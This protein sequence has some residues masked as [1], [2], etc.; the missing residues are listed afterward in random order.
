MIIMNKKITAFATVLT[1]LIGQSVYFNKSNHSSVRYDQKRLIVKAKSKLAFKDIQ[2]IDSVRHFF[3]DIYI[4]RVSQLE[5]AERSLKENSNIISVERN[6]IQKVDLAN[7]QS[8]PYFETPIN[9]RVPRNDLLKSEHF[10]DPGVS[11]M[12]HFR[13]AKQAGITLDKA[14]TALK[15]K[16]SQAVIVAVVDTGVD[17][18]HEDLNGVMWIN[19][20][21]I[22]NN[23]IDDD[24]NGYVDDINGINTSERD[25]N[26]DATNKVMDK[27]S[28]GSHVSGI[29]AA[30]QNNNKGVAG[31]ASNVKIMAL[32]SVPADSDET[33]IDIAE[34]FLYAAKNGA[35]IINCSFGKR[36]NEG[37]NLIPDTLKYIADDYGVLVVI[38]AGNYTQNIDKNP[39]YPASHKNE[40]TL[41]VASTTS[42]A[43]LSS[44]SNYG[45]IG[46]DIAAPGDSI[47]STVLNNKYAMYSGTSMATPVV[48]GIAAEIWSHYPHLKYNEIKNILMKSA[49]YSDIL[50]KKVVSEGRV[51]LYN[52]YLKAE[53]L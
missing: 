5:K 21:E 28:H 45:F 29:I 40:N 12:W 27:H 26:G 33:D 19:K 2:N 24:K 48:A 4:V 10:N 49:T 14:Y 30:K 9:Q 38:A 6:R 13:D 39:I 42:S 16:A 17:Y 25:S 37:Q 50:K 11:S 32:K 3:G 43:D 52:S 35:K 44:F 8:L 15:D 47:Y 22:P 31:I 46:V 1:L 41:V 7:E 20:D 53:N 34:A 51:D 23:N 36:I 18:S